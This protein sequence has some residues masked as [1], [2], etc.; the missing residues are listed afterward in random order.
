M[1]TLSKK[2]GTFKLSGKG[3][4]FITPD[5]ESENDWFVPARYTETAWT[6]D[7]VEYVEENDGF[8]PFA[9]VTKILERAVTETVAVISDTDVYGNWILT[10]LGRGIPSLVLDSEEWDDAKAGDIAKVK[11]TQYIDGVWEEEP[12]CS[13]IKKL[14]HQNDP[15]ADILAVAE[16]AGISNDFPEEVLKEA[17]SLPTQV[18]EKE[19]K[20]RKDFR[21]LI[22]VTIDGEHTKDFDDAVSIEKTDHGY[23]LYVHIADVAHYVTEGSALDRE[24]LKRGTST[25]LPDRTMP[26]L[27]VQL[28]NGICS[29][30]PKEDRLALSCIMELDE[31]GKRTKTALCESLIRSDERMTYTDVTSILE[32]N[33]E[34]R[35][36]YEKEVPSFLLMQ[37]LYEK[38]EKKRKNRGMISFT[39][40]ETEFVLD[41]KG[42]TTD[43]LPKKQDVAMKIIEQFMLEANE[44]VAQMFCKEKIPFEYRIHEQPDPV[45]LVR[46]KE[47]FA[48]LGFSLEQAGEK[49]RPLE[50]AKAVD[51][52]TG[53]A[54]ETG[55]G[56]ISVR[57]MNRA[58]YFPECKGHFGLA[59]KYYCHFTSPIRRYPDTQ[60]H[61][62]IHEYLEG[63]LT[64][65]R[66]AHYEDI[67]PQICEQNSKAEQKSMRAE[68]DADN[69]KQCEYLKDHIGETYNGV[70]SGITKKSVFVLLE[71][72]CEGRIALSEFGD[73]Y[74][75]DGNGI[76]AT[77]ME[78]GE[79]IYIGKQVKI[80]VKA[81]DPLKK[82]AD[83][84][85]CK[86]KEKVYFF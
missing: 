84:N 42:H 30:N 49:I 51:A 61:R 86:K 63:K 69:I 39:L 46:A 37:E 47:A 29:L 67:L 62:I 6:G 56:L 28:S 59:A 64:E 58:R 66:K 55:I 15:G 60:I 26:M 79:K 68:L 77:N 74:D 50:F 11:I 23:W 18:T 14:G 38:L 19:K 52:A 13:L 73:A 17:K 82:T 45:R 83:F 85:L 22:T 7:H 32:G 35:I 16:N 65:E 57:T 20:G 31:N 81:A 54:A 80:E 40:P 41:E 72:T 4:G 78:N 12:N 2:Q 75:A 70:I 44:A 48:N 43:V 71:N 53:T 33:E 10:P 34:L 24:A 27:P 21:N 9:Q 25:Y 76:S 36:R 1:R 3:Y 8:R 5:E